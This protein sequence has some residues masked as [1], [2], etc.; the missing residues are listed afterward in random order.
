[1]ELGGVDQLVKVAHL[2]LCYSRAF[3]LSAYPRESQ[4]MVFDA[5]ARAFAHLGGIPRR[6]IYDNMKT[7]IDAIFLGKERRY[8]RRFLAMC[9]HYLIE[10]TACTPASGWEKGQVEN[11]V[12]T[13]RGWLF[14]PKLRFADLP[15]LNA[16]LATRCTELAQRSHPDPPDR[17]VD[18]LWQ[19]ERAQL[20]PM[21]PAFDGFHERICRVTSTALVHFERNRYSVECAYAGR[22][23]A[24]RAYATHIVIVADS[25][26]V[27]EHERQFGRYKTA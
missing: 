8:N 16:W 26:V 21:L 22:T 10:P 4:E 20:Q 15:A 24:L 18:E 7:A 2:R 5:H 11:Q 6:G 3:F 1:M 25:V 27:G 19:E 17:T 12:G 14:A 23:V 13:V 9:N